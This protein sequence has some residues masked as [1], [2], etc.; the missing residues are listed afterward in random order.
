MDCK[1]ENS[2]FI[3]FNDDS[4]IYKINSSHG[5]IKKSS[6]CDNAKLQKLFDIFNKNGD[7]VIDSEELGSLF[8]QVQK[9][10]EYTDDNKFIR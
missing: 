8:E 10:L 9:Y 7:N 3:Q 6:I 2:C 1:N 5:E 4:M